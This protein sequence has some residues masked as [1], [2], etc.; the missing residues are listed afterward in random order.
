MLTFDKTDPDMNAIPHIGASVPRQDA[1]TKV[2]GSLKFPSDFYAPD[3][4]FAGVK[5]AGIPHARIINIDVD[6]TRNM[7]GIVAVLTAKDIRGTN[8]QGVV[9]CDQPVLADNKVRHCGDPVALV[10]AQDQNVLEKGIDSIRIEYEPLPAIF[11]TESALKDGAI[12]IHDDSPTGNL[13]LKGSLEKGNIQDAFRECKYIVQGSFS[14]PAQEHAYLETESGWA[15]MKEDNRVYITAAT[16]TPF[17]DRMEVARATG[18]GMENVCIIAPFCGGAFGGKDGISVQSLLCLAALNCP[19]RPVKMW[20]SREESLIASPKRHPARLEYRL[21]A[22]SDGTLH[23]LDATVTYDTGPYDHLGGAVMALGLEHAGGPYR[24]PNTSLKA[25]AVYTNNPLGGAFRAFG[26]AQVAASIEQMIDMLSVSSGISPM[27]IRERNCVLKGDVNSAGMTLNTSTG[28]LHCLEKLKKHPLWI[29]REK[30]KSGAGP[31]VKRGV[32]MAA[33]MQGMGYGPVIPDVANARVELT[34]DGLIRIYSGVADMG[35]GNSSTYIQIAGEILNQRMEQFDLI[36]PDTDKCLPSGSATASR[37]TYTFGNALIGACETLK[38]TLL[39]RASDLMMAGGKD[40]IALI[41]GR[42]RNLLTGRE[43]SLKDFAGLLSPPERLAT[44]RFRMPVAMDRPTGDEQLRLHGIPH[45]IF[46][47]AAHLA[48]V[49]ADQLTGRIQ[50]KKYLA[51]TDCGRIINPQLFEQQIQGGIAQAM[52]YALSED[53]RSK[54]GVT[55]TPDLSTY[56]IP[57]S[58][59]IPDMVSLPVEI[60]EHTGPF[61]LKGVGEVS[62]NGPLPAIANAV[63]DACGVRL[64]N[65]PLTP[66]RVLMEINS[67]NSK[68]GVC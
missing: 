66:E 26:V 4:L 62:T 58:L 44:H 24:I 64:F 52:G 21:G 5:R 65:A 19:G 61:G 15:V 12:L 31:F 1:F 43:I 49:E 2:T 30:W 54:E 10:I 60:P 23:A 11:D 42:L 13:L 56:I 59:D 36:S 22:K 50:I 27:E 17:R 48:Y 3:M 25:F 47:Y 46:S 6:K 35:Q 14:L 28:M 32:G 57:T 68:G 51:V 20:W 29:E 34:V 7:A 38:E 63:F 16:Q 40:E 41:P 9:R 8:R 37:T 45:A 55:I 67:M 53:F 33:V 39:N 18:V